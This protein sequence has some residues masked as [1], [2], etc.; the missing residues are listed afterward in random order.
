[1][2]KLPVPFEQLTRE[3]GPH[4]AYE[5]PGG[6]SG[7][8]EP[9]KLV[10]THCCFCGQGC[11]IQLKVRDNRVIGF[12]PW[13]EFP[14]NRG[15]LCPK[16]VKRYLQNN[17]PDRLLDPMKRV[18]GVGFVPITWDEAFETTA[19]EIRRIQA[20]HGPNSVAVLSGVSLS[21]EKSYL[22]GKF[23]RLGVKTAELDY[24]GRLC[25]VSAGAGNKKAF[26]VDRA[27]GAW[28]DIPLADVIMCAGTNV[29][30]CA[31]ITTDYIW[32]SRDRGGKLIMIDPRVTPLARTCDLHLP[33]RPGTDSA[34]FV[35]MLRILVEENLVDREFV[36]NYTSGWA[37][38]EAAAMETSLVDAAR[39]TGVN[40]EDIVRAARMWG[41]A[42]SSFLLHAR[43]IEQ[44]TKGTENVLSCINLV[45]ATGRIGRPGCGYGTITGQGNGQ[46]GREHGHKCDQ[47]PG[48]RD[49]ENPEHR[50]YIAG[51]WGCDESEI[52][53]K[54]HPA[55]V[56]ME[57]IHSGEIKAL[58]SICFNPLVSLPDS[59][60]TR[61][62]LS[63][64]E[65]Y[66]AID[67]FLSETAQHADIVMAG[68][69]HEEE[70]GTV[71]SG[72]A[73]V[74]R[75]RAA[76]TPPGRAKC[77]TDIVLELGRRFGQGKYF[78]HFKTPEDIFNELRVASR[79]STVSYYG[80]TYERLE[81]EHGIFWPCPDIGHPGHPSPVRRPQV[82]HRG[83][84][85]ALQSGAI[86]AKCGRTRRGVS[87][88]P[89][90]RPGG[91]SVSKRDSDKAHRRAR[92][93]MSRAVRGD[94]SGFGSGVRNQRQGLGSCGE[95]ARIGNAPGESGDHDS[96]GY[97]LHPLSLGG[98]KIGQPPYDPRVRSDQRDAGVQ[99]SHRPDPSSRSRRS[100]ADYRRVSAKS[101]LPRENGRKIQELS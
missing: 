16:G 92:R 25:M 60:F 58:I 46:G 49:I 24:N 85:G 93:P 53:R 28:T 61:E 44:H 86:P 19:R 23:A 22:M 4:L 51:V 64:L 35:A 2:A 78:D 7:R 100:R 94:P 38:T 98:K 75:I 31:P 84:E 27:A 95:P 8:G 81:K 26:G 91:F 56:I 72:E 21:N 76:V 87:N 63:R 50:A 74:N 6:W 99:K 96:P 79:F 97:G 15:K 40:L 52:P 9:E 70:E 11:G 59:N 82:P 14:F 80:M 33:V 67:F 43:G 73:R 30:E 37:D 12:E 68:S 54:G 13:E 48:N 29:A 17:H 1:M 32:R 10:K 71:T 47:L 42:K 90:H 65:H 69:L 41:E 101:R 83:R 36:E 3:F 89:H 66:T 57:M 34:L 62:A 55:P 18:E 39:I 88:Y 20:E 45:L 5:P 77:D